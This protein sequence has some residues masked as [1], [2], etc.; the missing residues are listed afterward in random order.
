M[1]NASTWAKRVSA[2]RSS[3]QTAD[4]F[5]SGR[6]FAGGTLRWWA[7]RLARRPPALV[8]VVAA[9]S[10]STPSAP[11]VEL[12]V[13]GVSVR[14]RPGFDGALLGQVLDVLAA[15]GGA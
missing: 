1:A 3:G 14:V 7:S 2:W 4:A 15:R 8:R 9:P 12:E 6:G 13:G 11:S 5:A 10:P